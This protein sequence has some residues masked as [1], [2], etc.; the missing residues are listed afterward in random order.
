MYNCGPTV[1]DVAHIGNLWSYLFADTVRRVL[2]QN[3]YQVRQVINITDFGHLS[4][5]A[6]SGNDKMSTALTREGKEL[7]LENMRELAEKYT[8]IFLADLKTLNINIKDITFPRASDFI[9]EQRELI[10]T[11]ENKGFAYRTTDGVYFDTTKFKDYGRLGSINLEGLREGARIVASAEKKGA[12]DFLLWKP[13]PNIGWDSPWGK[14][15]PGWH[16]ECSAMIQK[17]L[18]TQIDIHTG[19]IDLVPTH[20]NNEIAQSESASG[21]KPFSRFWLHHQFLNLKNEKMSKSLGNILNLSSLIDKGFHPLSLRYLSHTVHYRQ[22]SDFTWEALAAAQ[23]TLVRL[24][25]TAQKVRKQAGEKGSASE[26]SLRMQTA[27][28][29]DLGIPRGLALLQ[30]GLGGSLS[31]WQK[32]QMLV[33][34][35]EVLGLELTNPPV[36]VREEDRAKA[37]ERE[38]ARK[39]KDYATSDRLRTEFENSGYRVYDGVKETIYIQTTKR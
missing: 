3:G 7:T 23:E 11:L 39:R 12:T 36:G 4:S 2:K 17:T 1:Y 24:W 10:K 28:R 21:K 5:S 33:D 19:G 34:A 14:G 38:E 20:H 13:D 35:D 18:G 37:N 26:A 32:W 25:N 8:N 16:I 27:F 22:S 15:F 6:D 30:E 31:V 29:D 9:P